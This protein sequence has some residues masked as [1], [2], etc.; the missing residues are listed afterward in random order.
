M[1]RFVAHIVEYPEGYTVELKDLTSAGV[2]AA[3]SA[4]EEL[5]AELKELR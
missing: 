2:E 5:L 1:S 4:C 3:I